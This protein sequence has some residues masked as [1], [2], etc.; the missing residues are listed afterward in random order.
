VTKFRDQQGRIHRLGDGGERFRGTPPSRQRPP[1]PQMTLDDLERLRDDIEQIIGEIQESP[2]LKDVQE[3]I[4]L[5]GLNAETIIENTLRDLELAGISRDH[6]DKISRAH[7]EITLLT[8]IHNVIAEQI[9]ELFARVDTADAS[10]QAQY[11]QI[12]QAIADEVSARVEALTS[13]H[14]QIAEEG[15][16]TKLAINA[17]IDTVKADAESAL[18][19]TKQTLITQFTNADDA[20]NTALTE[21]ITEVETNAEQARI[22]QKNLILAQVNQSI[23]VVQ[24]QVNTKV[25]ASEASALASTQVE[26][27]KNNQFAS[28]QQQFN[29]VVGEHNSMYGNWSASYSLKINAGTIGGKPVI[30]GIG[31]SATAGNGSDIIFM[32][33]RVAIVQPNYSNST[34]LKY[35]F[36]VGTVNGVSTVG[37]TG[38]LLV[39]GSITANKITTNTLSAITANAGTINGGT[40]KTH[41]LNAQGQVVNPTEFRVEIS[42]VGT[43]PLWIGSG[44]KSANNAVVWVDKQGNA[45]F[46]GTVSAGNIV[47]QVQNAVTVYWEGNID[48]IANKSNPNRWIPKGYFE[49]LTTFTL[50]AP[51]HVGDSHR[52][53][54][55]LTVNLNIVAYGIELRLERRVKEKDANGNDIWVWKPYH[56]RGNVNG[57]GLMNTENRIYTYVGESQAQLIHL[58]AATGQDEQFRISVKCAE[59]GLNGAKNAA[60]TRVVS[61]YGFVVG[62]R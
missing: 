36:V 5:I 42:N 15:E 39:D 47:G 4:D 54:F 29:V 58:G 45:R 25:T 13:L 3:L 16:V 1:E 40:F 55:F 7:T 27:F 60:D 2:A 14:A 8:N 53:M 21:A 46:N 20:L 59:A 62:I 9:T 50:P 23:G 6:G 12:N 32:A 52:P 51:A 18:A 48:L 35:P 33:D 19:T 34:Q 24:Q 30:A 41:T 22:E 44:A 61:V 49:S 38:Q 10:M 56:N 57:I 28:L 43:W 37:I 17:R 26:A 31:L 11:Q